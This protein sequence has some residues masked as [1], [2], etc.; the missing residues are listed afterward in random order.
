MVRSFG[1]RHLS[2]VIPKLCKFCAGRQILRQTIQSRERAGFFL[3]TV[4]ELI[5]GEFDGDIAAE[6]WI[7]GAPP[8]AWL[9]VQRGRHAAALFAESIHPAVWVSR[10]LEPERGRI[11]DFAANA[12]EGTWDEFHSH[13]RFG[14][15]R[16]FET[17]CLLAAKAKARIVIRVPENN[18]NPLSPFAQQIQS[19]PDQSPADAA[20]LKIGK[21][22]YGG[23]CSSRDWTVACFDR[24]SAD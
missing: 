24:H 3:E 8:L 2:L 7:A 5:G 6:A 10:A 17:P 14:R 1:F 4:S 11:S 19:I 20:T 18:D 12:C 15:K 16:A 13:E 23:Q 22:G 9:N 21:H